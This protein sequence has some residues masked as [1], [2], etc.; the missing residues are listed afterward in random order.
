MD[1]HFTAVR[2]T[3]VYLT[4]VHLTRIHFMVC[5]SWVGTLQAFTL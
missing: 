5:V 2:L 4:S 3:G 1:V